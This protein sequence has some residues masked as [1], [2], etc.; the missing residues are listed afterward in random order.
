MK[1]FKAAAGMALACFVSAGMALTVGAETSSPEIVSAGGQTFE[2]CYGD[3]SEDAEYLKYQRN[4]MEEAIDSRTPAGRIRTVCREL[5]GPFGSYLT[6]DPRF[7]GKERIYGIDVSQWQSTIDWK[8]V[9][10]DGAEYAIVRLGYRGYGSAGTLCMDPTFH[11]NLKGAMD[12]GL[13]VGVY[14]YTQAITEAEAKQ[15]ADYC[16]AALKGYDLQLPVYYDIESVDYDVGRLDSAGLSKA[17]KTKLCRAFCD[18]IEEYGYQSG[19]YA[20]LYWLNNMIDGPSLGQDYRVW[21]AAYMSALSYS[22]EY[23]M[24]QY[25]GSGSIDGI[26]GNVDVNVMYGVDHAPKGTVTAQVKNG[27][28]KWNALDGADGYTVYDSD[29]DRALADVTGTSYELTDSVTSYSVAPYSVHSGK[30]Y[31]GKRSNVVEILVDAVEGLSARRSGIDKVTVSWS[32][33]AG[34]A[35]YEVYTCKNGVDSYEGKT[36]GT[37]FEISGG[38]LG[39]RTAKVRACSKSGVPGKFSDEVALPGNAP[40]SS[41]EI[42]LTGTRL[43]W[44]AVEDAD[45]YTVTFVASDGRDL[46]YDTADTYLDIDD[47]ISGTYYV[48]AY[49]EMEGERFYSSMSNT[50]RFKGVNYPPQGE[51]ELEWIGSELVW[52]KIDDAIGYVIYELADDG[53]EIEVA[54]VSKRRY[55]SEDLTGKV[56]FVKGYNTKDGEDFFTEASNC[57]TISLPGVT[58]LRL[59][60]LTDSCAFISWDSVEGC[61][62]YAVFLDT[63]DGYKPYT[64][65][66]GTMAVIGGIKDVKCANVIV[67]CY[68][69]GEDVTSYGAFSS[70]LCIIGDGSE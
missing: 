9:K 17:A 3:P 22:G 24:W 67:K 49:I 58:E 28:L 32:S 8:K 57:V 61:S 66:K 68:I 26:K 63:G 27:V 13:D 10:A 16:A 37:S 34:A 42:E 55:S 52:N 69:G 70:R 62:E 6:H 21:V 25:T 7:D 19:V 46:E 51:I 53:E 65:V 44:D 38:E 48:E 20:N 12:A 50:C 43:V 1:L 4:M 56:Y 18:R 35:E 45:G 5:D 33:L 29:R 39:K 59:N 64:I 31:Y 54:R 47:S 30:K 14:F 60:G 15:E 41:P 23:D 40:S 11:T 2:I 36:S